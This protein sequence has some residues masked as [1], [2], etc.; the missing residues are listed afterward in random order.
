[1]IDTQY[2]TNRKERLQD[3][4]KALAELTK[5]AVA[6]LEFERVFRTLAPLF[7]QMEK[8]VVDRFSTVDYQKVD[9]NAL[10]VLHLE[11][12]AILKLRNLIL[13]GIQDGRTAM[14]EVDSI[15][16]GGA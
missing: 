6:G 8:D 11:M 1:M 10:I 4:E 2:L 12:K 14:S 7:D 3:K 16:R 5:K 9:N 15:E 13:D